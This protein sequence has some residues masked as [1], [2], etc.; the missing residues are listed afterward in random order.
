M[1]PAW[2][3]GNTEP[4]FQSYC[5][6]LS[7]PAGTWLGLWP[8]LRPQDDQV[9]HCILFRDLR[10][11]CHPSS[12][13][14][15]GLRAADSCQIRKYLFVHYICDFH[16]YDFITLIC[17]VWVCVCVCVCRGTC[18]P[19]HTHVKVRGQF[20]AVDSLSPSCDSLIPIIF[21]TEPSLLPLVVL[22]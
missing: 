14:E 17:F 19:Q 1:N 8:Q 12:S 13:W 22:N 7:V 18:K 3:M 6:L 9:L 4:Q 21:S 15:Q 5:S 20:V 2:L 16:P 10:L 11:F